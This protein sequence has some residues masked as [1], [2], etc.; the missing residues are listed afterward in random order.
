MSVRN[1]TQEFQAFASRLSSRT[2]PN[3][4]RAQINI[5]QYVPKRGNSSTFTLTAKELG[6]HMKTTEAELEKLK[7]LTNRRALFDEKPVEISELTYIIKQNIT[8]LNH[9][10]SILQSTTKAGP[11]QPHQVREHYSEVVSSLQ[12]RLANISVGF[13]EVL[14]KRTENMKVSKE[15]RDQFFQSSDT[16]TPSP[17]PQAPSPPGGNTY[18]PP[19]VSELHRRK[20]YAPTVPS[21]EDDTTLS[22]GIPLLTPQQQQLQADSRYTE[23]RSNALESIENTIQELGG[24]F[25]QLVTMVAEQRETVQRIGQNTEDIE[26]HINVAQ[27]ELLRYYRNIS[28]NRG[29]ML[30]IFATI[31]IF[32]TVFTLMS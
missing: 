10:I 14:E 22:L 8:K 32:F 17:A 26:S 18:I 27:G 28:S 13:K 12:N 4:R 1:R 16:R 23:Q 9:G 19:E 15:R 20:T 24:M 21:Q 11:K 31:I 29:L 30:K 25:Q 7:S 3:N 5:V 2:N 6:R